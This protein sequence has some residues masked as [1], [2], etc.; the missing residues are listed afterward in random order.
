MDARNFIYAVAIKIGISL[1]DALQRVELLFST[2][3][4]SGFYQGRVW[5]SGRGNFSLAGD[6][7]EI[8]FNSP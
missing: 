1:L 6:N 8:I 5:G 2:N 4:I 7:K 3:A